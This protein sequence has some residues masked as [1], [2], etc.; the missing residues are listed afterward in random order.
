MRNNLSG[1]G[2]AIVTP[3]LDGGG[4]DFIGLEKLLNHIIEGGVYYIVVLGTTGESVVLSADEK[5][6]VTNFVKET[7]NVENHW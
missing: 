2:I 3:F 6:A 1:T 5:I 7:V 4:V